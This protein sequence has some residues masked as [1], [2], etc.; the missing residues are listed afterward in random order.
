[1]SSKLDFVENADRHLM[2]FWYRAKK[3]AY[4]HLR[5]KANALLDEDI[6][7]LTIYELKE[8][9]N[10]CLQKLQDSV[11]LDG[12]RYD[13]YLNLKIGQWIIEEITI[14]PCFMTLC[15]FLSVD[16]KA[17][18]EE[19]IGLQL[20]GIA[21]KGRPH[22]YEW[23]NQAAEPFA[24]LIFPD[25]TMPIE[26]IREGWK[27]RSYN[28]AY[29]E[30][31][32]NIYE[33][34]GDYLLLHKFGR[35]Y[36]QDK[37]VNASV[38]EAFR[39]EYLI[40]EEQSSKRVLCPHVNKEKR[41]RL[42]HA[43]ME[44]ED[45]Y[46]DL[47]HLPKE[48]F[49]QSAISSHFLIAE[50]GSAFIADMLEALLRSK[51]SLRICKH[52]KRY[53]VPLSRSDTEYCERPLGSDSTKTCRSVGPSAQFKESLQNN[54]IRRESR[55]IYNM[56]YNRARN[57]NEIP[58]YE[59]EFKKFREENNSWKKN[60]KDQKSSSAEYEAWLQNVA[61]QYQNK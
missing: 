46:D 14:K 55:R 47:A 2:M 49:P 48:F 9:E 5:Y 45:S 11:D 43:M 52:C 61:A 40:A 15:D 23:L 22:K 25:E 60:V 32:Q 54:T 13:R 51:L 42:L 16:I 56:L 44:N 36:S 6:P 35:A 10:L 59:M 31:K 33:R 29:M 39:E 1:M 41:S 12:S 7:D 53:F 50:N 38:F 21:D 58:E 37:R 24:K 8:I 27:D 57:H 3:E 20:S 34:W 18:L 26:K 19:Y 17:F 28:E 30:L 4:V